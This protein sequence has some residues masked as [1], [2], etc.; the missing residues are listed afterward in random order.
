MYVWWKYDKTYIRRVCRQASIVA[1]FLDNF[2]VKCLWS[3]ML[4]SMNEHKNTMFPSSANRI[5]HA[6]HDIHSAKRAI[7]CII[8]PGAEVLAPCAL[9]R[10]APL[11]PCWPRYTRYLNKC[12][13]LC[14]C[15]LHS[16]DSTGNE[17]TDAWVGSRRPLREMNAQNTA[18]NDHFLALE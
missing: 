17:H 16:S 18:L 6:G 8:Y 2:F 4:N 9:A 14:R 15:N 10:L 7:A 11:S 3:G 1:D 12:R 5:R 13:C